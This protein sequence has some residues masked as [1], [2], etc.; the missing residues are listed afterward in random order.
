MPLILQFPMT[1]PSL[2]LIALGC[3]TAAALGCGGEPRQPVDPGD[4]GPPPGPPGAVYLDERWDAAS[5]SDLQDRCEAA[6]W[7]WS[8]GN[9]LGSSRMSLDA[10]QQAAESVKAL[11]YD[12][13]AGDEPETTILLPIRPPDASEV[14]IEA[15]AKFSSNFCTFVP[16]RG[17][18]ALKFL[19]FKLFTGHRAD[20][21]AGL[22]PDAGCTRAE[23][24]S[25]ALDGVPEGFPCT[26]S[27]CTPITNARI[28]DNKPRW[29]GQWHRYRVHLKLGSPARMRIMVDNAVWLDRTWAQAVDWEGR[30]VNTWR[31]G[32]FDLG[33][34]MND[35]SPRDMTLWWGRVI[36]YTGDPGW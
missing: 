30:P 25:G 1:A 28:G 2:R 19:L 34:N 21:V 7:C 10:G 15:H 36:V 27:V 18:G 29:D 14:W 24:W 4:P 23:W 5:I 11:R 20:L 8:R 9:W 13:R 33:A 26:G 32:E 35:G 3:L 17:V 6:D 12:Y 22:F 16:G 31:D